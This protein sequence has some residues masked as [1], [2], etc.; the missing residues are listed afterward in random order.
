MSFDT[1]ER[2]RFL[3]DE[4]RVAGISSEDTIWLRAHLAECTEC[5]RR[6]D[7]TSRMLGAMSELSFEAPASAPTLTVLNTHTPAGPRH[8]LWWPLAAA[9]LI[10]L[11]AIPL[12]KSAHDARQAEADSLLLDRVGD[13]V[14]RTVPQA[15]EPLMHAETGDPQ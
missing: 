10:L 13:H 15:L 1:H 12:Y 5:A 8:R 4:S 3:I 14:S 9:A 7:E 2:A 11:A 6:E